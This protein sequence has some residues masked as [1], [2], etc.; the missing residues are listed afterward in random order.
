MTE[1]WP[2]VL[3]AFGIGVAFGVLMTYWNR[4]NRSW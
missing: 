2:L 1:A 4:D 3:V